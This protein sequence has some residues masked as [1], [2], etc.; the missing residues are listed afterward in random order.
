MYQQHIAMYPCSII[1]NLFIY[2]DQAAKNLF[3]I[4]M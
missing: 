3:N 4:I 2:W 1:I